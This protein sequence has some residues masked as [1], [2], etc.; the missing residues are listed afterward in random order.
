MKPDWDRQNANEKFSGTSLGTKKVGESNGTSVGIIADIQWKESNDN[1]GIR[2]AR[3]ATL[4]IGAIFEGQ[5]ERYIYVVIDKKNQNAILLNTKTFN[6][7]EMNMRES[8][9]D[10]SYVLKQF[11][12]DKNTKNILAFAGLEA[13]NLVGLQYLFD[14]SKLDEKTSNNFN[15]T[16]S[17]LLSS[18]LKSADLVVNNTSSEA[19]ITNLKDLIEG[20]KKSPNF[21]D[22]DPNRLEQMLNQIAS[23][24]NPTA[25]L[26]RG[27]ADTYTDGKLE[28]M[29]NML[30]SSLHIAKKSTEANDLKSAMAGFTSRVITTATQIGF[31]IA[32]PTDEERKLTIARQP[33]AL[34]WILARV[35]TG[36]DAIPAS[37][38][39]MFPPYIWTFATGVFMASDIALEAL[40]WKRFMKEFIELRKF[41]PPTNI[42]EKCQMADSVTLEQIIE[43][44]T[45]TLEKQQYLL[46]QYKTLENNTFKYMNDFISE[47][48]IKNDLSEKL[49]SLKNE[50]IGYIV[51]Q[52][53]LVKNI[54]TYTDQNY[55]ERKTTDQF[56]S[57]MSQFDY[58]SARIE[59]HSPATKDANIKLFLYS[60]SK[61]KKL[62]DFILTKI[63]DSYLLDEKTF[64]KN[65]W[66]DYV[67]DIDEISYDFYQSLGQELLGYIKSNSAGNTIRK[68]VEDC[69]SKT[70]LPS[71][72]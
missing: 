72:L 42:L 41:R 25:L 24:K 4:N 30:E 11:M 53:E 39:L 62:I 49:D 36:R 64:L 10:E 38:F 5:Y 22:I 50:I 28:M 71:S 69:L 67:I 32:N 47:K 56:M 33:E 63:I 26:K 60:F 61:L 1:A 21:R 2:A 14:S 43:S 3:A 12:E 6:L 29:Y 9:L 13:A 46:Q 55:I 37:L 51:N 34:A 66:Y 59:I 52:K 57:I 68:I 70:K 45:C 7:N 40:D 18:L 8:G 48:N 27:K 19:D 23:S 15:G 58:I 17:S 31:F 20:L 16:K 35:Y 44:S 54:K 65:N